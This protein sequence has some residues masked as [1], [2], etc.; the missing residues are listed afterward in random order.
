[1]PDYEQDDFARQKPDYRTTLYWNPDAQLTGQ[2]LPIEFYTG[3]KL[4][5]FLI[6]VE[7]ITTDGMPFI[8]Q[9]VIQV[10]K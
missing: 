5:Q 10:G 8:G 4:S 7:G 2:P 6:F 9:E 3:D 1:M